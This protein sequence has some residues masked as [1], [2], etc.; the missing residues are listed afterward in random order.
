MTEQPVET[1]AATEAPKPTKPERAKCV[2]CGATSPDLQL[3]GADWLC[4]KCE[5]Y[6]DQAVC[7][8]CHSIVKASLLEGS[9]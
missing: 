5:H 3:P 2:H 7:P 1:A 9:N 8:T 6:Q 4:T